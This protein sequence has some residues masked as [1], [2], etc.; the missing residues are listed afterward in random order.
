MSFGGSVGS[1][2][3]ACTSDGVVYTTLYLKNR[4]KL[5]TITY[6]RRDFVQLQTDFLGS[7]FEL[8]HD[9]V[10]FPRQRFDGFGIADEAFPI[11]RALHLLHFIAAEVSL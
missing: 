3:S 8:V 1:S 7:F 2:F 6:R 5:F 4:V 10:A 11:V 9:S